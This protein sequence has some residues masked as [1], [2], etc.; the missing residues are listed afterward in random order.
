MKSSSH[1]CLREMSVPVLRSSRRK[2]CLSVDVSAGDNRSFPLACEGMLLLLAAIIVVPVSVAVILV[3]SDWSELVTKEPLD[4]EPKIA[5]LLEDWDGGGLRHGLLK[6]NVIRC[7][8]L[9]Y[10]SGCVLYRDMSVGEPIAGSSGAIIH[11]EKAYE[12]S[13]P[14]FA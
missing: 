5:Y 2:A 11:V 8:Y 6:Y 4:P 9:R 1:N 13:D 10:L 14:A 3:R 12:T 7:C